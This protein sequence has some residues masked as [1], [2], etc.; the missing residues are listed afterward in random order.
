MYAIS[1]LILDAIGDDEEKKQELASRLRYKH[2][3]D[4]MRHLEQAIQTGVCVNR[5]R[6]NLAHALG[7]PP[8]PVERALEET[9]RQKARE[10]EEERRLQEE[11]CR[12]DF[13]PCLRI[14][15]PPLRGSI[16]ILAITVGPAVEPIP[17]PEDI[18]SRP[19]GEQL[20]TVRAEIRKH[21]DRWTERMSCLGGIKAYEYKQTFDDS[22]F[23]SPE[24]EVI[25]CPDGVETGSFGV[26]VANKDLSAP[27]AQ[28]LFGIADDSET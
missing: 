4:A 17:L 10:A 3:G 6:L 12:R 28:R 21:Q 9:A 19:W 8:E 26:R 13:R 5:V 14:L 1:R 16:F 24:G 2:L 22:V 23:F 15:H 20:A 27:A 25:D 11:Q 18:A 7:G